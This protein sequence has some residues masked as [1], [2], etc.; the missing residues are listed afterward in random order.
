MKANYLQVNGH[1]IDYP[2]KEY[3]NGRQWYRIW[4][5]GWKECGDVVGFDSKDVATVTMPISFS[6]TSFTV[7]WAEGYKLCEGGS[8]DAEGWGVGICASYKTINSFK[9]S[10]VNDYRCCSY[11]ARGF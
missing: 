3:K 10:T 4:K 11:I 2:I 6:N 7:T 1:N 9:V 5:S 8:T